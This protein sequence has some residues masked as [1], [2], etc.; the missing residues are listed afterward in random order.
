M[1]T[2]CCFGFAF[3]IGNNVG[4]IRRAFCINQTHIQRHVFAM[5]ARCGYCAASSA[6]QCAACA[7]PYCGKQCQISD[8]PQHALV[9]DVTVGPFK[10]ASK[11]WDLDI[12]FG[13]GR[14][15]PAEQKSLEKTLG[16][17]EKSAIA[18]P[19][20]NA[21]EFPLAMARI[22]HAIGTGDLSGLKLTKP[23]EAAILRD[24]RAYETDQKTLLRETHDMWAKQLGFS[25]VALRRESGATARGYTL[26]LGGSSEPVYV[27][28]TDA[29][30]QAAFGAVNTALIGLTP[31]IQNR[32]NEP[33]AYFAKV[34][35]L[36]AFGVL[37]I[38]GAQLDIV[39]PKKAAAVVDHKEIVNT[40]EL[41]RQAH[42]LNKLR[43]A[44]KDK[45][46]AIAPLHYETSAI[47]SMPMADYEARKSRY[48]RM[49]RSGTQRC[50]DV[51]TG[52]VNWNMGL[53][54]GAGKTLDWV[55]GAVS[56]IL[57]KE[58]AGKNFVVNK[59]PFDATSP[60]IVELHERLAAYHLE[61]RPFKDRCVVSKK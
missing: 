6:H 5:T 47:E 35:A 23:W 43:A 20:K 19:G 10:I 45:W 21:Y 26:Q 41:R 3:I 44:N 18:H 28:E 59:V 52:L 53:V 14:A 13:K 54:V 46:R 51:E 58:A 25:Q 32:A 30:F 11:K 55:S 7:M 8:W 12:R 56:L 34:N 40:E 57:L 24:I 42:E 39:R 60:E 2:H 16:A 37:S 17:L 22:L 36:L 31:A 48:T 27:Y 15:V 29:A 49:A 50:S 61:K 4:E 9:C 33:G 38:L 1:E